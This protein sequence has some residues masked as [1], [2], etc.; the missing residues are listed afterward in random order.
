MVIVYEYDNKTWDD[1]SIIIRQI[2][3]TTYLLEI[4]NP[5]RAFSFSDTSLAESSQA[6]VANELRKPSLSNQYNRNRYNLPIGQKLIILISLL[7]S[8][9]INGDHKNRSGDQGV[10]MR[11]E[12]ENVLVTE[13]IKEVKKALRGSV[14]FVN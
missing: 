12:E 13:L 3:D 7:H 8:R 11:I 14:I 9:F 1:L 10:N 5:T 2:G 4:P 6:K